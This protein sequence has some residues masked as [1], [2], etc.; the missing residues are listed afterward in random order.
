MWQSRAKHVCDLFD[1]L[2]KSTRVISFENLHEF[3]EAAKRS[4]PYTR[5]CDHGYLHVATSWS[6]R[7]DPSLC[8][9]VVY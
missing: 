3:Y 4:N 7:Y 1:S 2:K 9:I 6:T 8:L 5:I